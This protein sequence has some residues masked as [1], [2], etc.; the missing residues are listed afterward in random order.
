[1]RP[2]R[3]SAAVLVVLLALAACDAD[4]SPRERL[5]AAAEVT[6]GEGTAAFTMSANMKMGEE[7]SGMD[8]TMSGEGALDL[9]ARTGRMSMRMPG[10]GTS[11]TML[12]DTSAV[13]LRIPSMLE[14]AGS[15]WIRQEG[16]AAR[17]QGGPG[18]GGD[19]SYLVDVLDAVQGDVSE[20]GA[21]T[22]RGTDV[23]GYG[24]SV[25]G[26]RLWAG[27]E[28]VP[29][30]VRQLD[31]PVEAWLDAEDR[32]RRMVMRIDMEAASAAVRERLTDS[33]S[34]AEEQRMGAM[35]SM[36]GGT[37]TLTTDFYDFGRD[38][39]VEF[40]DPSEVMDAGAFQRQMTGGSATGD[41][42]AEDSP[43]R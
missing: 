23:R 19:P 30:A 38:V 37:M 9:E 4:R 43:P 11:V 21:D 14:G 25:S 18:F 15:R 28:E 10:M 17:M 22:V 7:G 31:V 20:L 40:P 33:A 13:Y 12:F 42:A 3:R 29:E 34:T 35:M 32:L 6:A 8:V 26:E 41:S 39:R 24:F 27:H 1:M 5:E 2:S 36:M 16:G